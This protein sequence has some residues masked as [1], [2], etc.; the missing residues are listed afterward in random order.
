MDLSKRKNRITQSITAV[1]LVLFCQLVLIPSLPDSGL[2]SIGIGLK[3]IGTTTSIFIALVTGLVIYGCL[4][5]VNYVA[6]DSKRE[7]QE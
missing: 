7:E 3:S 2:N 1:I 6:R 5:I 4:N